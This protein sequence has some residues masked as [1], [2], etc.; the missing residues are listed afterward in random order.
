MGWHKGNEIE[1]GVKRMIL[2]FNLYFSASYFYV[3][4]GGCDVA[5]K[6]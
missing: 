1:W 6:D 5:G 2:F 4:V 3:F